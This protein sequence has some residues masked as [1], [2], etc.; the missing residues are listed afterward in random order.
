M[1]EETWQRLTVEGPPEVLEALACLLAEWGAAGVE[2][3]AGWIAAYFGGGARQEAEARVGR[4]AADLGQ[5]L[6]WS[7]SP[8]VEGW[9]DAWKEFFRPTQVSPRLAVCPSWEA[10]RPDDPAVR[11]I[12]MDPGRAFGTGTHE[13]TR[14]CLRIL[15]E[16]L[17]RDLP[18]ELLDVG[19]GSGILSIGSL[20]LGLPAAL[21]VDIDPLAA[22]A[23]RENAAANGVGGRLRVVC[24]DLRSIRGRYP[25]VVANILYQV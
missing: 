7:W 6:R 13:T 23:T 9:Q 1:A 12:R 17:A 20:L 16:E 2:E 24:G 10:W 5:G 8:V 11:V 15:D 14:V 25:L 21:A 18:G 22:S 19:C 3:G 4:Y